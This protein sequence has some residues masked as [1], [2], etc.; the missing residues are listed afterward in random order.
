VKDYERQKERLT[1]ARQHCDIYL[2]TEGISAEEA[3][4]HALEALKPLL[5]T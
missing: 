4:E 5:S 1:H 3:L 2:D